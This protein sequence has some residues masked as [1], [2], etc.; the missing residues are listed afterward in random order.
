MTIRVGDKTNLHSENFVREHGNRERSA[1]GS[2]E[3]PTIGHKGQAGSDP[4]FSD[5]ADHVVLVTSIEEDASG[6]KVSRKCSCGLSWSFTER[7]N[8]KNV[9]ENPT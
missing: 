1:M 7:V 5:N 8:R 2:I 6:N 4:T 9:F 3:T